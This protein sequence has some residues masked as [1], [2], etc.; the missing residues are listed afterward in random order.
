M[1]LLAHEEWTQM[2][3]KMPSDFLPRYYKVCLMLAVH[4]CKVICIRTRRPMYSYILSNESLNQ[5]RIVNY[6]N[7][8][9]LSTLKFIEQIE[10]IIDDVS[11]V[12]FD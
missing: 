4:Q 5:M 12:R 3:K 6:L 1:P 7:V 9:P 11:L 8:Q 2:L 10:L